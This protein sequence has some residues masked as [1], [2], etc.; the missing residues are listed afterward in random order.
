MPTVTPPP[1][2]PPPAAPSPVHE[3]A[4]DAPA[5]PAEVNLTHSAARGFIWYTAQTLVFKAASVLGQVAL[6]YLLVPEAAGLIM[7]A[8]IVSLF[9]GMLQSAG[10][11]EVLIRRQA[12]FDRWANPAFWM[13]LALGAGA[14]VFMLAAAPVA[15]RQFGAPDLTGVI[16]LMAPYPVITALA[17]V[18]AA[19][20]QIDLRFRRLAVITGVWNLSQLVFFIVL[21]AM[22]LGAHG[23]VLSR[24]LGGAI[25]VGMLW[26]YAR[27]P[28]RR[29]PEVRRWRHLLGDSMLLMATSVTYCIISQGD[30][31][32]IGVLFT[33]HL[34][35]LY[36]FALGLSM[37]TL[38]LAVFN[39]ES[40]IFP[41][42]SKLQDDVVRQG[43]AFVRAAATM[44]AIVAPLCFL[45]GAV[46]EPVILLV[47]PERWHGAIPS[48]QVLSIGMAFLGAAIPS[49]GLL[50]AQ[51]RFKTRFRLAV[52]SLVL[53]FPFLLVGNAALGGIVGIAAGLTV[54]YVVISAVNLGTALWPVGRVPARLAG[55]LAV[56]TLVSGAAVGAAWW[57][58]E[59]L[60]LGP[61]SG[62]VRAPVVGA[63]AAALYLPLLR[64]TMPAVWNELWTLADR[65]VLS[66]L[67]RRP[68]PADPVCPT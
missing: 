51:G 10:I 40:L 66:R 47:F 46:A 60:P 8:N 3:A 55:I 34:A 35:G 59:Q 15:A 5:A 38:Q 65:L 23:W 52:V 61:G 20:M 53:F 16:A 17:T 11:R 58:G 50:L 64:L 32:V 54:Y 39:V 7:L 9:A 27:V 14:G 41:T 1:P 4:A 2:P 25:Y 33:T 43:Q 62:W 49:G 13:S 29:R 21:A 18:P 28:V 37:Q 24:L 68:G 56:P 19:A 31:M 36:Y 12:R 48:V 26:K 67:A 45:Q 63:A 44:T 6:A 42:L 22:G 57:L 30:A